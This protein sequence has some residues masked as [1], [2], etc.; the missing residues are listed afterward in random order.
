MYPTRG[1]KRSFYYI[2]LNP[3]KTGYEGAI[4]IQEMNRLFLHENF[5]KYLVYGSPT[6]EYFFG[7]PAECSFTI[8]GAIEEGENNGM[9]HAHY[10]AKVRHHH[11]IKL[12]IEQLRAD[13]NAILHEEYPDFNVHLHVKAGRDN[14]GQIDEYI[15]KGKLME[16]H[17][18]NELF[19]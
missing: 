19:L 8:N 16:M 11:F 9:F 6:N 12:N 1:W 2:T 15:N 10:Q 13:C 18:V 17:P 14:V 3:N 7:A 5:G 4:L